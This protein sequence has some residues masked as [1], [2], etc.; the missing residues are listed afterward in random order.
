MRALMTVTSVTIVMSS[1]PLFECVYIHSPNHPLNH[2]TT[3]KRSS[4]PR[5]PGSSSVRPGAA[6]RGHS[7][8]VDLGRD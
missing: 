3:P 4:I 5:D 6:P 2:P 1:R 7:S 8:Q